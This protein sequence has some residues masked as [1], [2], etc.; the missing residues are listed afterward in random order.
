MIVTTA[1][2]HR[3]CVPTVHW[4]TTT[5]KHSTSTAAVGSV[6]SVCVEKSVY[7]VSVDHNRRRLGVELGC[8]STKVRRYELQIV[9]LYMIDNKG[10]KLYVE[11]TWGKKKEASTLACYRKGMVVA[12]D[13]KTTFAGINNAMKL[14]S[15][16][17]TM[18]LIKGRPTANRWKEHFP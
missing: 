14:S 1:G 13:E 3:K 15:A 12:E 17:H 6:C 11:S 9:H 10:G 8:K 2:G 5:S 7:V 18:R 4:L 16:S